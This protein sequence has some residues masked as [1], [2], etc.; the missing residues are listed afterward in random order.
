MNENNQPSNTLEYLPLQPVPYAEKMYFSSFD[1]QSKNMRL[2]IY[3][4]PT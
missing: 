4:L 3:K 1:L 2:G